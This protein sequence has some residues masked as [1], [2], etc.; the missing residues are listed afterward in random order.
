MSSLAQSLADLLPRGLVRQPGESD[1]TAPQLVARLRHYCPEWGES[2][3]APIIDGVNCVYCNRDSGR[4]I[5]MPS[6][7]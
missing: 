6:D 3:D 5:Y 2:V 1:A 4:V 7:N